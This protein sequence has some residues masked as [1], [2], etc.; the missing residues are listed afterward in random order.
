M[1]ANGSNFFLGFLALSKDQRA[2][3][4][5]V[6]DYCRLID[7]IV[8]EGTIPKDEARRQLDFWR[9]EIG[10]LFEG[11]PTHDIARALAEP[12]RAFKIRKEDFLEMIRGCALDLENTRYETIADLE[13]YMA[14]VASSVGRMSVRIF[15]WR[16][17]PENRIDEFA[18][19]FGYA[20]QLT[21]ILRDVGADLDMDRVY[22][23]QA[24][25]RE[26]GV[27]LDSRRVTPNFLALM[28]KEYLRAKDYYARARALVDPRDRRRL[29]PAEIMAHIYERI[30]DELKGRGY[31]SLTQKVSLSRAR[32]VLCAAGAVR[33][34]YGF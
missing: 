21:N 28:D 31:P 33:D 20:F 4:S 15:G 1:G 12:V 13:S 5:A 34:C 3:L 8:D 7:D 14:G 10:R 22:L 16:Y 26:A 30:L 2:A 17:T 9:A 24:D 18:T 32:K 11:N 6:Y 19:L 29:L 25:L 27:S 23:P